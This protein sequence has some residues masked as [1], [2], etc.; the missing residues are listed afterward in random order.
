[1]GQQNARLQVAHT[2]NLMLSLRQ[3]VAQGGQ[4]LDNY[5]CTC[6]HV[7]M[8]VCMSV[9]M[10]VCLSVYLSVS[11]GMLWYGMIWYGMYG[12]VWYGMVWYGMVWYV[13]M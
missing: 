7:Y 9:C 3:S 12:M 11:Y 4:L 5:A 6:I 2:T 13:C 8:Y 10:S 1:M